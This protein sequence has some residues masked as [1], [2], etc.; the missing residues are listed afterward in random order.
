MRDRLRRPF[1]RGRPRSGSRCGGWRG[2]GRSQRR[3]P[4]APS[5]PTSPVPTV[6][7]HQQG[8]LWRWRCQA[9]CCSDASVD[10]ALLADV[11]GQVVDDHSSCGVC[12]ESN[13]HP[14]AVFVR[15]SIEVCTC[16]LWG[17]RV[18]RTAPSSALAPLAFMMIRGSGADVKSRGWVCVVGL[19]RVIDAD[20]Q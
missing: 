20:I 18:F 7:V 9:A 14:S 17:P 1:R 11:G 10:A 12:G 13:G 16:G 5:R 6:V 15:T 4:P 2:R 8:G 3:R 19:S